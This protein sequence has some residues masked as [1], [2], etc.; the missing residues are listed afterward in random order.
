MHVSEGLWLATLGGLVA[1]FVAEYIIVERRKHDFGAKEATRW[2]LFYLVAALAFGGFVWVQFGQD[3]AQQFIAGWITE[4]SLSVDN[5]FVFI[6]LMSSFSVPNALKHRVLLFG[7]GIAIVFRAIMIVVGVAAVDRFVATFF[8]FAGFLLYTAVQVW[9]SDDEEPD[10]EGN[11]FVRFVEK[12]FPST[13]HYHD[14][15]FTV[16]QDGRRVITPLLLVILALGT[17]D[18]LF[19]LDS[20]PAVLGLT[21][22]TYLI[23][24]VNAFALMGLRQLYFV[25]DGLMGKIIYL[26][27]GLALILG[28]IAVKLFFEALSGTTH[29]HVPEVSI[30]ASLGFIILI[31]IGT[32]LV[33]SVAVR[34]N[35]ELLAHTPL[36]DVVADA[37]EHEGDALEVLPEDDVAKTAN[38]EASNELTT[39]D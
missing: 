5:V 36:T 22:E 4:Y 17:T 15:K 24:V 13:R 38:D 21:K 30:A 26:S 33:S 6:V 1:M 37:V 35:P 23:V 8:A 14:E 9:R 19:A 3:Y 7:V 18:V 12:N 32:V 2:V 27:K 16:V 29:V 28:F 20:I 25:L 34:R 39:N 31:L 11:T 10:P